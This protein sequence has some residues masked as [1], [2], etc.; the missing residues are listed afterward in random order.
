MASN[1]YNLHISQAVAAIAAR[2]ANNKID[3]S[4]TFTAKVPMY[5]NTFIERL[6]C[7]DN[8]SMSNGP[9]AIIDVQPDYRN[10]ILFL[11][12][13][14]TNEYPSIAIKEFPA[15]TPASLMGYCLAICYAYALINDDENVRTIKSDFAQDFKTTKGLDSILTELRRLPVPPFMVPLLQGLSA[16]S[17]TRKPNIKFVY[18]L[19]GYDLDYDYGRSFPISV[20]FAAHNVIAT[21]PSNIPPADA[22]NEWAQTEIIT[23]PKR[24]YVANYLGINVNDGHYLNW[25]AD[26]MESLYNP[27]T[28]RTN[29]LR[30]TFRTMN[31][32][33]QN[34]ENTAIEDVNP[35]M[36]LLCMDPKNRRNS[37]NIL[38]DI[39]SCI[40]SH[41]PSSQAL[42]AIEHDTKGTEIINHYYQPL[43][44]P[45]FHSIAPH[46]AGQDQGSETYA[47]RIGYK[48][49]LK[50]N[51]NV[52]VPIPQNVNVYHPQLYLAH[53][54]QYDPAN[55][56]IIP[57]QYQLTS[58]ETHDIRHLCFSESKSESIY[59]NLITGKLIESCELDSVSV[60]QPNPRH[61]I[62][63][64]N[65]YFLESAVPFSHVKPQTHAAE[66][67][68]DIHAR[69]EH[70]VLQPTV[71]IDYVNRAIDAIPLFGPATDEA[72]PAGN[73]PGFTFVTNI[74]STQFAC[75]SFC[76]TIPEEMSTPKIDE[77]TRKIRA[78]SSY[79]Y[80][81][82]KQSATLPIRNRKFMLLNFW[83]MF[84][85]N[86]TLE[87]TSHPSVNIPRS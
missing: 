75:N 7:T 79:R 33:P 81:N 3:E 51:A 72:I 19:A 45:T 50:V 73:I 54:D 80:I 71:R 57:E 4:I 40:L 5:K 2:Y 49:E 10:I 1:S 37:L 61:P 60:P 14:I 24:L 58:D 22:L 83:T 67:V 62:C 85:T 70:D 30:P 63:T 59:F 69:T 46:N 77:C 76:Y 48:A 21:K 47:T 68:Y 9:S 15:M 12:Y 26:A 18:S 35:Y 39:S 16:A 41:Y 53:N 56:P 55:D 28:A 64:E 32:Y 17:D 84:G 66:E 78:W 74:T 23:A 34:Y 42:G 87:E 36:Y 52:T 27:V 6:S 38:K 29:T 25:F 20:F 8:F 13:H 43:L 82:R 65:S 44:L 86:T 31:L 11:N